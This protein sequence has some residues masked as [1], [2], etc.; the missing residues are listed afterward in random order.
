MQQAS[1]QYDVAGT[2]LT[3][4]QDLAASRALRPLLDEDA[5]AEGMDWPQPDWN[6]AAGEAGYRLSRGQLVL[7]LPWACWLHGPLISL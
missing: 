7:W 2:T 6:G 3:L 4:H 1:R 5:A